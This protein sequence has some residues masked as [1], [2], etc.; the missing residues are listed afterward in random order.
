MPKATSSPALRTLSDR[1]TV[2]FF[3]GT[4]ATIGSKV[5]PARI[6]CRG[7]TE[8]RGV[9]ADVLDGGS[10]SDGTSYFSSSDGVSI[11]LTTGAANGGTA[12]G[13]TPI[14]IE[15]LGGS[16]HDDTLIGDHKN[17]FLAGFLGTDVL[18]GNAGADT[19]AFSN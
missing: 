17:N 12:A 15:K 11:N 5:A 9:G 18:Q 13:D 6:G 1:T 8:T 2:I 16:K 14:S 3:A 19:F 4:A 7:G 10:G